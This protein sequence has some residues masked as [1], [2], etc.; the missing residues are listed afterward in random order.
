MQ[1]FDK[2]QQALAALKLKD[3]RNRSSGSAMRQRRSGDTDLQ[4]AQRQ[5]A[6]NQ[7][8]VHLPERDA[9]RSERPNENHILRQISSI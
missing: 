4:N 7:G 2:Q 8:E 9:T 1:L 5:D 3:L 6:I